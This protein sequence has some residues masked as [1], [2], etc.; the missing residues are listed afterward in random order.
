MENKNSDELLV[1][2]FLSQ[3]ASPLPD[4][5]FTRGVM[6]RLPDSNTQR[7]NHLWTGLCIAVGVVAFFLCNGWQAIGG[8][9]HGLFADLLTTDWSLWHNPLSMYLCAMFALMSLAAH[10]L[11][12]TS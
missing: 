7:L 2:E 8:T 5:G 12:Q 1:S 3:H 11:V 4:D 6:S 9:L 10:R